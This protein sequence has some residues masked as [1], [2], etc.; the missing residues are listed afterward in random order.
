M[1]PAGPVGQASQGAR[2]GVAVRTRSGQR[3]ALA[4]SFPRGRGA[5]RRPTMG[6]GGRIAPRTCRGRQRQ[7]SSAQVPRPVAA[8]I[9]RFDTSYPLRDR[10][11]PRTETAISEKPRAITRTCIE[12]NPK[13]GTA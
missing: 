11:S 3:S 4:T 5:R 9:A 13:Q 10:L 12:Q 6:A 7:A 1:N 8:Q 2:G